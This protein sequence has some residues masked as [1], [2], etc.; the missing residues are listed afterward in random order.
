M[1][2]L[3]LLKA[4]PYIEY[5][6]Q[7]VFPHDL[8]NGKSI[9]P[10]LP[11]INFFLGRCQ[12]DSVFIDI[13]HTTAQPTFIVRSETQVIPARTCTVRPGLFCNK[14]DIDVIVIVLIVMPEYQEKLVG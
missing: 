9:I 5:V 11:E 7:G 1:E 14:V 10:G 6:L 4:K 13:I 12:Q 8:L 3:F 2:L